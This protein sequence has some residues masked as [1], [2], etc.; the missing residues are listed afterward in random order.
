MLK[1]PPIEMTRAFI[2]NNIERGYPQFVALSGGEVVGWCDVTPTTGEPHAHVG[3]LGMG[4]LPAFR[5]RGFGKQLIQ[6]ALRSARAFGFQRVQLTV[7]QR[8]VNAIELYKKVGFEIEGLQRD[9]IQVDG[10]YENLILM[11]VQF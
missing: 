3:I 9:A 7:S 6:R 5:G 4:L 11:A 1:A 10:A 2:C 8:N